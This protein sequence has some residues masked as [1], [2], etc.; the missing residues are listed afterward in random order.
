MAAGESMIAFWRYRL[1]SGAGLNSRSQA[2]SCEGAL[3]RCEGGYGCVH[4]WPALGDAPLESQ[5]S[6][7]ARGVHT[8]LTLRALHCCALDGLA[9]K[10]GQDLFQGLRVPRSH[11][12][13]GANAT[14]GQML[15]GAGQLH[16]QGFEIVKIK[17]GADVAHEASRIAEFTRGWQ[18]KVRIDFNGVL[19]PEEVVAFAR[20]LPPAVLAAIDFVEDPCPFEAGL[21]RSLQARTGLDFAMDRGS[22]QEIPG[23]GF[24]VRVWKPACAA[25]PPPRADERLVITSS[26]DHAIGQL[27]AAFEAARYPGAV[28]TC[29]LVTHPLFEADAFFAQLRVEAGR[30]VPPGGAGLGFGAMLEALPWNPLR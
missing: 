11:A 1:R 10:R 14:A 9:R 21:W 19:R 17:A 15:A 22:E 16:R 7:L 3:L 30:L 4:P 25:P 27:F 5:L 23:E 20:R 2:A 18:G 28:D 26:M 29:G 8:P 12:T 24:S 6:S 13:F